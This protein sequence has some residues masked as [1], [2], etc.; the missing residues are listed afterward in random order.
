MS[1]LITLSSFEIG[2]D[3]FYC[4][5]LSLGLANFKQLEN[6]GSDISEMFKQGRKRLNE[7]ETGLQCDVCGKSFVD[8]KELDVHAD[9]HFA[10]KL[11]KETDLQPKTLNTKSKKMKS[12]LD[13]FFK[14]AS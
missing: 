13:S 8:E 5:F 1:A 3:N 11:A 2:P 12:T 7:A 10:I 14:K 9:W 6:N 4:K